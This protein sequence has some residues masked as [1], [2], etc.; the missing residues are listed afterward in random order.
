M[1][2][3]LV[4]CTP[5][6]PHPSSTFTDAGAW[7][8]LRS[9]SKGV[10][11]VLLH[12]SKVKF[13]AHH[14]SVDVLD[15]LAGALEVGG[16]VVWTGDEDLHG[17]VVQYTWI[18]SLVILVSLRAKSFQLLLHAAV[19]NTFPTAYWYT[20]DLIKSCEKKHVQ[21]LP[22]KISSRVR[23][24]WCWGKCLQLIVE[25]GSEFY[26]KLMVNSHE[27]QCFFL[28]RLYTNEWR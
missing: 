10:L 15:V 23:T 8:L 11:L 20:V 24:V 28:G 16:G 2:P 13:R 25:G 22:A 4:C 6:P 19:C 21:H 12:A 18:N 7:P 3:L 5:P 14:P 26:K 1:R 9:V 17:E 27:Y